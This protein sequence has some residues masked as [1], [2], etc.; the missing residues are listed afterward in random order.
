VILN[1][2][3]RDPTSVRHALRILGSYLPGESLEIEILREK[4]KRTL[5]IEIPD[6]R[7]SMIWQPAPRPRPVAAP[8]PAVAPRPVSEK[9]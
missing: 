1:I 5:D 8:R 9:T 2:D 7:S 6:N 3:G 4:K